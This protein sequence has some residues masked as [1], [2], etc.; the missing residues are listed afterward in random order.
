[1]YFGACYYPEHW[2]RDRWEIDARWMRE[3][4]FNVVRMAEFAWAKLEPEEGAYDFEWLDE[5]IDLFHRHG[6]RT[7]LG[8]P[9]AGPPIWLMEKHPD[10]Y[11]VDAQ[12]HVRGFGTRRHYCF[13][14]PL[15]QAHSVAI[16]SAMAQRYGS[17]SRVVGW[18]IDN[19]LGGIQTTRCYCDRCRT[20]F[21]NWLRQRYET[22]EELNEAW[23]T[24]FSS[25]L[26][27]RWEQVHLPRYSVHQGHNP[28]LMLDYYR[29]ASD[30]VC[31][32]QRLQAE[33][34]RRLCPGQTIT[35]NIMGSYN[36]MDYFKLAADLDIVSLDIYPN[37]KRVPSERAFRTAINHDMTR[38]FKGRNYWV[39]EHQSGTPG[40][41]AMAATPKPGEL[42][43]WTYQSIARGADAIV[44]FRWRTLTFGL[45][46]YWH[47]ILPH[48]GER[49]RLYEEVKQVGAELAAAA[50]LLHGTS[51]KARVA[52]ARSFD[53]EWVFDIQPHARGYAYKEHLAAYYRYFHERNILL[54]FTALDADWSDYDLVIAPNL[55]LTSDPLTEKAHHYVKSG[56]CLV[57]DFRAGA[58]DWNSRMLPQKLPGP[59][60]ELLGIEI[61]DYGVLDGEDSVG[62]VFG[63]EADEGSASGAGNAGDGGN[64]DYRGG[65]WYDVI[66]P[67]TADA[68]ARFEADYYAGCPAVTR[69]LYGQGEAYYIGTEPN[70]AA[71][72]RL[73]DGL[74]RKRSIGPAMNGLPAGVEAICREQ[75]SRK[76]MFVINH[77]A[78]PVTIR[79][80][81]AYRDLKSGEEASGEIKLGVNGVLLLMREE[82]P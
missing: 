78:D 76:I 31:R 69:N 55:I 15:F 29:F 81:E 82:N 10:I 34:L 63:R 2:P 68:V 19:E 24:I 53:Q 70:Q 7:I 18:Q 59:Y 49:G 32:Y 50:P 75:G 43:R 80:A 44:Y 65:V 72:G 1:M 5:A 42:R 62:I 51:P 56:G 8:T 6:I 45:E 33:A 38:G 39:L 58:K 79:L 52:I 37:M 16:A 40:G 77:N 28:G 46:E 41:G 14:H 12:G 67:T 73:M 57:M 30:S 9:T 48:H 74:C 17:D 27:F 47:G 3:A 21:Q 26:Y 54:D 35:T 61:D 60:R 71:L 66:A 20:A 64:V 25:Q 11:P 36:E 23:G 4:G 22:I 13:N